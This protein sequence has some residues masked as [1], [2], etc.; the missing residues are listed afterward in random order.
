MDQQ[1]PAEAGQDLNAE[2]ENR[3]TPVG[4]VGRFK[5]G[6]LGALPVI[7]GIVIVW[8]VF[9]SFND[10]FLSPENLFNL[11]RQIS[12]GGV[13]SLGLVLMLLIREIDLSVGSMAGLAGATLA[14]LSVTYGWN[15]YL[16]IAATVLLGLVIGFIQGLI[17]TFFNVPSFLVTLGGFLILFGLQLRVLGSTGSV[18]FPFEGTVSGIQ[19]NTL[20]PAAGYALAV[21]V[22]ACYLAVALLERRRHQRARLPTAGWREIALH[23][24]AIAVIG[25]LA[26]WELNTAEGVPVALL[27]FLGLIA[28]FWIVTR[29]TTYGHHIYGIG[30]NPAAARRAGINVN[31]VRLSVFSLCGGLAAF[32]GVMAGS[33]IGGANIQLGGST[34]LLYAIA[35]AVIG[36]TSLFGGY[37]SVWSAVLGWLVIGSIYNGM[38]LLN[39]AADFQSMMIGAVLILAVVIDAASRRSQVR[40]E[41]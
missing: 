21:V 26:V 14:V 18:Q 31:A 34:L 16:A 30:G 37:G 22:L 6:Q 10:R 41:D 11:S 38:F 13:V 1:T 15:P 36:G 29:H 39:L 7:V 28:V 12:Y 25:L 9:Q 33:Y 8:V 17:R 23:F 3:N 5:S 32:G 20:P 24:V 27:I 19:T 4:L 2:S 35:A 40:G